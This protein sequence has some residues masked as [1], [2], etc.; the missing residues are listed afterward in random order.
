MPRQISYRLCGR[1]LLATRGMFTV[2]E[3]MRHLAE[4]GITSTRAGV[5]S[6]DM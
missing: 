3:L 1:E 5:A 6:W 2:A 4:R